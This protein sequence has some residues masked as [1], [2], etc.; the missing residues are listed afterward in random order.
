LPSPL[1]LVS[2]H[3]Q[4]LF[5]FP[6]LHFFLSVYWLF[7]RFHLGISDIYISCFN[8]MNLLHYLL[9]LHHPAP[10]LFD[11]LQFIALYYLHTQMQ[12]VSIFFTLCH[13]LSLPCLSLIPLE[14]LTNKILFSLSFS[15]F[16]HIYTY[17]HI[18]IHVYI[19]L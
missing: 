12:C 3:R 4:E 2:T 11:S 5:Y 17:N 9:F 13:S 19:Y 18:C 1:P 16:V 10:L 6:V 8:Q 7:K 14:R 15:V